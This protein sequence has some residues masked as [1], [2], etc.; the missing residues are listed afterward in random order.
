M[1]QQQQIKG[2]EEEENDIII[3]TTTTTTNGR[4]RRRPSESGEEDNEEQQDKEAQQSED[5]EEEEGEEGEENSLGMFN[6]DE[7]EGNKNGKQKEQTISSLSSSSCIQQ[8]QQQLQ[9][10]GAKQD[11]Q[12][13]NDNDDEDSNKK[14][15]VLLSHA[16]NRLSK[17][18][19]RLFDPNRPRG[20]VE[21]PLVIPLNDEFLSAFGK[22]EKGHDEETGRAFEVDSSAIDLVQDNDD[23]DKQHAKETKAAAMGYKVKITN[24]AFITKTHTLHQVCEAHG[25]V[26]RVNIVIDPETKRSTGR[27]FV[28]FE[29]SEDAKNCVKKM[30]EFILEGRPLRVALASAKGTPSSNKKKGNYKNNRYYIRDI[31]TKC[32]RC[33]KVGHHEN[34]CPN[35]VRVL[36]CIIC[37]LPGHEMRD[38]PLSKVCFNCGVP[39]HMSRDCRRPRNLPKRIVCGICFQSGHHKWQCSAPPD[40]APT[41]DAICMVCDTK[42][43]LVCKKLKTFYS[44]DRLYCFNCGEPDHHGGDCD[45]PTVDECGR[46]AEVGRRE[47]ERAERLFM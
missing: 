36:P 39:G 9:Q 22:R 33:G 17:W 11:S 4:K 47:V 12:Q 41:R 45:R 6:D 37:A 26:I 25:P 21:G 42:G 2:G 46:D 34:A 38:C 29:N 8:Q 30:N 27:A 10:K 13:G 44:I 32:A 35:E 40:L 20:L 7:E 43:H 19:L 23:D 18:A 5:G 28:T 14:R 1:E 16:K 15:E 31:S 3:M 24:L